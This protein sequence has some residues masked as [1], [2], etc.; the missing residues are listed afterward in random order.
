MCSIYTFIY[1]IL[2][3]I[4]NDSVEEWS[5][6]WSYQLSNL[7]F[8]IGLVHWL[9]NRTLVP[10]DGVS[11][12]LRLPN[13]ITLDIETYLQ[14]ICLIPKELSRLCMNC[15]RNGQYN[16]VSDISTF[17]NDLYAGFC[18]LNLRNDALRRRFDGIKYEV[19]KIDQIL[20]DISVRKLAND[21]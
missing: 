14:G 15:V 11:K 19:N 10:P 1:Y 21:N 4:G 16:T 9:Q 12:L 6:L 5:R 7:S 20:Y 17:V 2:I 13:Q 3:A 8:S 18:L